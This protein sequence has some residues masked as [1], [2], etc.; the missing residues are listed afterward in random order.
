MAFHPY[1]NRESS[2]VRWRRVCSFFFPSL[3]RSTS[4]VKF[5]QSLIQCAPSVCALDCTQRKWVLQSSCSLGWVTPADPALIPALIPALA[6]P[7]GVSGGVMA[8]K[9]HKWK[10]PQTISAHLKWG[11][12]ILYLH[13]SCSLNEAHSAS[14]HTHIW[15]LSHSGPRWY[16][17]GLQEVVVLVFFSSKH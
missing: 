1:E 12:S 3:R 17:Q 11:Q 15:L 8:A 14:H 5:I 13:Y 7:W 9:L 16:S 4:Q 10:R 2:K 6:A